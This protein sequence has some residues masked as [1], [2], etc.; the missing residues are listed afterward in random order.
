M[1]LRTLRYALLIYVAFDFFF[2]GIAGGFFT[3]TPL[4]AAQ[5]TTVSGTVT[6]PNGLAYANGTITA[7]LISSATPKFTATNLSYTPPSQPV[8]LSSA[9]SFVMQLADNTQ[10]TPGG[11]T[12][13]FQVCSSA[14][15]VAPAIGKGPLCFTV[16][17]VTISGA[18]QSITATLTAAAPALTNVVG[19]GGSGTV[20]AG[21]ATQIAFYSAS[22]NTVVSNPRLTDSGT[23]LSYTG[24]GG[25]NTGAN[26][27][28]GGAVTAASGGFTGVVSGSS[29][30]WT[31]TIA[32]HS[33]FG[34][35]TGSAAA[36]GPA[37]IGL[38]DLPATLI[39]SPV[40]G[41]PNTFAKYTGAATTGNG[42]LTDNGSTLAYSGAGGLNLAGG[43][44]TITGCAAGTFTKA[45]GTGCSS[46][47]AAG[48][49]TYVSS[50]ANLATAISS[51]GTGQ[52]I[53]IDANQTISSPITISTANLALVCTSPKIVLSYTAGNYLQWTASGGSMIGCNH[54][55]PGST[56][57]G[58]QSPIKV[59]SASASADGFRFEG[60]SVNN[61]GKTTGNGEV[62]VLNAS[63]VILH[64]NKA[65]D[66]AVGASITVS[67]ASWAAPVSGTQFGLETITA[68]AALPATF[69]VGQ[70]VKCAGIVSSGG[71]STAAYN[72][73]YDGSAPYF[74]QI[75]SVAS[76]SFTVQQSGN[77]GTYTSGGTCTVGVGNADYDIF[78][79]V[80]TANLS[81]TDWRVSNNDVGELI[82]HTSATGAAFSNKSISNNLLHAGMNGKTEFCF[83]IGDFS[84]NAN[85]M[86]QHAQGITENGNQCHL[87]ADGTF[88]GFSHGV[89]Q[90]VSESGNL[91]YSHGH[92][93]TVAADEQAQAQNCTIIGNYY[94]LAGGGNGEDLN[95]STD[96]TV[97]GNEI[98]NLGPPGNTKFAIQGVV[99]ANFVMPYSSYNTIANNTIVARSEVCP[100]SGSSINLCSQ[101]GFTSGSCASSCPV[102]ATFTKGPTPFHVGDSVWITN[103]GAGEYNC[104][105][106]SPCPITAVTASPPYTITY[107]ATGATDGVSNGGGFASAFGNNAAA[108]NA[109]WLQCGQGGATQAVCDRNKFVNNHIL[110]GSGNNTTCVN[111][112][113]TTS[114]SFDSNEV[115]GNDCSFASFGLANSNATNTKISWGR[116]DHVTRAFNFAGA[117]VTGLVD[118]GQNPETLI[119]SSTGVCTASSTLF[120]YNLGQNTARTCTATSESQWFIAPHAGILSG[121][122]VS[123]TAAGTN[124]SS[125]VVT[126]RKNAA[127]QSMTCT[128]GTATSCSDVT[129]S[130]EVSVAQ[131]D[132]ISIQVT[133]QA[134]DTLAGVQA[135]VYFTMLDQ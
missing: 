93:Y 56:L 55:G 58:Q 9:G 45:D 4:A 2:G 46:G 118:S 85:A 34:N 22:T 11:S 106:A 95:R 69:V 87:V 40:A 83:E 134:A 124:A 104:T 75:I 64:N 59:G 14:A 1:N 81:L 133:T 49:T 121:L 108:A 88:G 36:P 122:T 60:N 97:S 8:G 115:N 48:A 57:T 44:F 53:Y 66:Q 80:A 50:F 120:L 20:S 21:T 126:V 116:F 123:A 27:I 31:G 33:F 76:P 52:I 131:G 90:N 26:P 17:G 109:L 82:A 10:L 135:K 6:D 12:W 129:T 79:N 84:G 128:V 102:V 15:S 96:C 62:E 127:N 105:G 70:S 43:N 89:V 37:T 23:T 77:P 65:G 91:F 101:A 32:A 103:A 28:V 35:N 68:T 42:L 30:S 41:T 99:S 24:T 130:H 119:G 74:G 72:F 125:G 73:P 16:T 71:T 86:P 29:F 78:F 67:T 100:T 13:N 92:T 117:T 110:L 114:V 25:I 47:L 54:Q 5:F 3:L 63:H 111:L 132:A 51:V 38:G 61:F 94:D 7:T 107:T 112:A 113:N 19:G 98:F 39:T 18:S